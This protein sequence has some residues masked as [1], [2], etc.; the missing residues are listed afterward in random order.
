MRVQASQSNTINL[1][2]VISS[3]PFLNKWF[4]HTCTKERKKKH[5]YFFPKAIVW[6]KKKKK[7]K[8]KNQTQIG[9][10]LESAIRFPS[11]KTVPLSVP[12]DF[13]YSITLI[14]EH[15]FLNVASIEPRNPNGVHEQQL[16]S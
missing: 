3:I 6:K 14:L 9:F 10:E 13:R 15:V 2:T 7:K 12:V 5:I 16:A 8:K 11:T 4:A 1:N